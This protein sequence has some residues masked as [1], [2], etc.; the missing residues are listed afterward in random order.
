M[1]NGTGETTKISSE[2][3]TGCRRQPLVLLLV[4]ALGFCLC[5]LRVHGQDMKWWQD[6]KFGLFLH[7]GLYSVAA[8]DWQGHPYKGNEHFML[9]ERIPWKTYARLAGGLTMS[10]YDADQWVRQAK[11]A[12]MTYIVI[13]AKHHEGFAM[14]NSPSSDYNIVERSPAHF[15]PMRS[16]ADACH[17]YGVKLCFYYSLGR[18][19]Q[20]PDVPTNWPTKA[21][22]SNTW[23]YPDED[24]KDLEK[25]FRRKVI[26]QVRELLT[27]YG[28]VGILWFDTAEMITAEQS[29][30]LRAMIHQLQPD[31]IINNR[32][33]NGQG[34]YMVSEQKI[35]A[36]I[37]RQPWESCV[38]M[39][40][41]WGYNRYDT[42]WKSA[43]L[44]V[45]QLTE[46]VSKGGNYL[47]NVGPKADGRFPKP[48]VDR[49]KS[50]GT[51]MA[52]NRESLYG[53]R[54][55]K[56]AAEAVA[57]LP[58]ENKK[59]ASQAAGLVEADMLDAVNDA[60]SKDII[61]EIRFT[62]KNAEGENKE[63]LYVFLN[64][65]PG[66][67]V[68]V[69]S[70]ASGAFGKISSLK[71]LGGGKLRWK[72]TEAGLK[73]QLPKLKKNKLNVRVLA[74]QWK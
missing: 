21:G 10:D 27:Q 62:I 52:V 34:D 61:P 7:W 42:V 29:K 9:Y 49:L 23:D 60:T 73:V 3:L 43:E 74:V 26:P 53:T 70:L 2:G 46:T 1:M 17:K 13:T 47:L 4:A 12:G 36:K 37:N 69:R 63:I 11:K 64:S 5:G 28:P 39:S 48:A 30:E 66:T 54:P 35:D 25:Y 8:G 40:S 57:V 67:S 51:W 31:C 72:Q 22:R 15:D 32:I 41:G 45:R 50:I 56:T 20:D 14:Y 71:L 58:G 44:L 18:D 16:L 6:G 55:W 68:T 38:T 59:N 19:W 24:G 33:G 65:L